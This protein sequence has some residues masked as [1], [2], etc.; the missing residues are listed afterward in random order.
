MIKPIGAPLAT[1]RGIAGATILGDGRIVVILDVG[2]LV[3]MSIPASDGP[4]LRRQEP[5]C[6]R[7]PWWSTTPSPCAA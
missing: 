7:W 1:I 2:A 6:R 3:R 5:T 4:A